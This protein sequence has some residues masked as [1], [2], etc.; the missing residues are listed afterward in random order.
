MLTAVSTCG[1]VRARI[2]RDP[3]SELWQGGCVHVTRDT[4]WSS[5]SLFNRADKNSWAGPTDQGDPHTSKLILGLLS[6]CHR[7][8]QLLLSLSRRW[9][10]DQCTSGCLFQNKCTPDQTHPARR[11]TCQMLANECVLVCKAVLIAQVLPKGALQI[12]SFHLVQGSC[13]ISFAK[14]D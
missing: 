9:C 2:R 4:G 6:S 10:F 1:W 13:R 8:P 11:D 5:Q 7:S 3:G 12:S 14:S